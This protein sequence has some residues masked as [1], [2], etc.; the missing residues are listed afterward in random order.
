METNWQNLTSVKKGNIGES[1][2]IEYLAN[3]GFMPYS[4][5]A[6]GPH[7]FDHLV[8]SKNKRTIFIADSKTKAARRYYP[9]TGINIE[10][11]EEYTYIQNKYNIKVYIFFVDEEKKKIYGNWLSELEK[12]TTVNHNEKKINYPLKQKNI[13]YFPLCHTKP[14]V[15]IPEGDILE[16]R[17]LTTKKEQYI[18]K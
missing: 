7:P 12:P 6:P 3:K 18:R 16:M 2:V 1:L 15:D 10:H 13:I 14:V 4:P 17:K 11:Y 5:A 9:D 8:A